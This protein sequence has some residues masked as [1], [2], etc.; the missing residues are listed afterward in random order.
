MA[1]PRNPNAVI[2]DL[3][4]V[5]REQKK[6][7]EIQ[8]A[9][10]AE[11]EAIVKD[12]ATPPFS[13]G[14][15]LRVKNPKAHQYFA[16][17]DGEE[18]VLT[19][20]AEVPLESLVPGMRVLINNAGGISE[21]LA[22]VDTGEKATVTENLGNGQYLLS[23][24]HE[25][26]RPTARVSGLVERE[27][28]GKALGSGTDVIFHVPTR[29]IVRV[30]Q[31]EQKYLFQEVAEPVRFSDIIGQ[32]AAISQISDALHLHIRHADV[33]SKYGITMPK[34]FLLHGPP[35]CGKTSLAKAVYNYMSSMIPELLQ[36]HL[37][38]LELWQAENNGGIDL[39]GFRS[40]YEKF[41][42][43]EFSGDE[44]S[45]IDYL[46]RFL[47]AYHLL[48][49][50]I[51]TEILRVRGILDKRPEIGYF[52]ANAT[53]LIHGIVGSTEE[54]VRS[55]IR[56]LRISS[57]DLGASVGVMD[58]VDAIFPVRGSGISDSMERTVVPS[59]TAELDNLQE[60]VGSMYTL[61]LTTNR[62]ELLD[63]A[64][65]RP[66]RVDMKLEITR[67]NKDAVLATMLHYLR[68]WLPYGEQCLKPDETDKY[69]RMLAQTVTDQAF[70]R[71]SSA[72][73][74][75]ISLAG[76][77]NREIFFSDVASYATFR[78]IVD[79]AARAAAMRNIQTGAYAGITQ[80]DMQ[81]AAIA[82]YEQTKAVPQGSVREWAKILGISDADAARAVVPMGKRSSVP[83]H[84]QIR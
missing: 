60:A 3:E 51:K 47:G 32:D 57:S 71:D 43:A 19:A 17:L 67:P 41:K 59:F 79:R 66:G 82:E 25:S 49:K 81:T 2:A 64:V 30:L 70:R 55:F 44:A 13:V 65:V 28:A 26:H 5:V 22:P 4:Q 12:L 68:P 46:K 56:Q 73:I 40:F 48:H 15:I 16:L 9:Q 54:N 27:L 63:P 18:R 14:I 62:P 77:G 52:Y 80:D 38:A 10:I 53:E 58:E 24:L 37:S 72:Y 76:Q 1:N 36:A 83:L 31:R 7:L 42:G 61:F 20:S 29:L 34:G 78:N 35:G 33:A 84:K 39:K 23:S 50:D 75:A 6:S 69:R 21:A 8:G 11:F 45:A 74:T